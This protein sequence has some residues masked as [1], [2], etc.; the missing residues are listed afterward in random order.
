MRRAG[1]LTESIHGLVINQMDGLTLELKFNA[2]E[3][4]YI[5]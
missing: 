5:V 1:V 2:C 3:N 4:S